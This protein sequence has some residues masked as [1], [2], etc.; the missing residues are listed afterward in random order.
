VDDGLPKG[1]VPG[2][3]GGDSWNWVINQSKLP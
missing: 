1:A 2:S 3:D